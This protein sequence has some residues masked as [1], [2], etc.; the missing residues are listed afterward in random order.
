MIVK[1]AAASFTRGFHTGRTSIPAEK[2]ERPV[3]RVCFPTRMSPEN[4]NWMLFRLLRR[5]ER[6]G[7]VKIFS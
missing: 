2:S 4:T 5:A 3:C 7:T 1:E 6:P